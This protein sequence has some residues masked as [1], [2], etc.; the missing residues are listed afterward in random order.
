MLFSKWFD[1]FDAKAINIAKDG[2][3]PAAC[4]FLARRFEAEGNVS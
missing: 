4:F 1:D 2:S 3:N